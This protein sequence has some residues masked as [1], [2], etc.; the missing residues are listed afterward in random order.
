M[1]LGSQLGV[2]IGAVIFGALGGVIG[3]HVGALLDN[4]GDGVLNCNE[5][6]EPGLA[7]KWD[8]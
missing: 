3:S 5:G 1:I 2:P 8:R 6:N 7:S 4:P